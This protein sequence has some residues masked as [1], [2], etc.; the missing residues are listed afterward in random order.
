MITVT[1]A[2]LEHIRTSAEQT[3]CEHLAFRIAAKQ[4]G[5]GSIDYGIGFDEAKDDDM[6]F[7]IKGIEVVFR[8]EYGPLL[9]GATVDYVELEPGQFHFIFLNP[10]DPNYTPPQ[11]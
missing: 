6:I 7:E 5:D 1:P 11:E 9:S 8:P 10:N 2:A 3:Q 4:A